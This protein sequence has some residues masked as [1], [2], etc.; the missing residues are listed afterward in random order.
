MTLK[1]IANIGC[2]NDYLQDAINID[3]YAEKADVRHDL[4][5]FPYPFSDSYFEEIRAYNVIEHMDDVIQ[6]MREIHRIGTDGCLVHLRVP[7]FRS[8]CLYEDLTHRHG[9]AWRSLDIFIDGGSVYGNY[10]SFKYE[11]VSR[12]YTP[13]ILPILYKLLSKMPVLTDNFLSKFVPMASI[14]FILKVVKPGST[15]S[16]G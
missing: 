14:A 11:I 9:F 15:K 12:E 4:N 3:L 16:A 1:R 8:A 10:A 13:Y 5:V 7:H 6:V 2:G